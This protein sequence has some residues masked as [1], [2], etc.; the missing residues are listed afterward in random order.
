M[1]R[2]FLLFCCVLVAANV[3][4]V[5]VSGKSCSSVHSTRCQDLIVANE[6][7]ANFRQQEFLKNIELLSPLIEQRSP[8]E[9]PRVQYGWD[10]LLDGTFSQVDVLDKQI[11]ALSRL[12]GGVEVGVF[13]VMDKNGRTIG[14]SKFKIGEKHSVALDERDLFEVVDSLIRQ[15]GFNVSDIGA[16]GYRHNHPKGWNKGV[17]SY[18]DI[19]SAMTFRDLFE[20][21][22]GR[23]V[24][25]RLGLVWWSYLDLVADPRSRSIRKMSGFLRPGGEINWDKLRR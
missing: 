10:L 7:T 16:I 12:N 1:A 25:F 3:S 11:W 18:G 24:K 9:N 19:I 13:E 14:V 2:F 23:S 21:R 17:F 4:A 6:P 8:V 20:E 22:Y 5:C 15:H